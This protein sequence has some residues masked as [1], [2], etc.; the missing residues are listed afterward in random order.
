MQPLPKPFPEHNETTII[1][2]ICYNLAQRLTTLVSSTKLIDV[3]LDYYSDGVHLQ[4]GKPS[5]CVTQRDSG[6]ASR[7]TAQEIVSSM[8]VA[9]CISS[10]PVRHDSL[11]T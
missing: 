4:V 10:C 3:E 11:S 9:C 2:L 6:L 8:F 5:E 1:T 7:L